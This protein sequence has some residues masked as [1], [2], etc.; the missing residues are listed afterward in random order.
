MHRVFLD[1]LPR[2]MSEIGGGRK[3]ILYLDMDNTLVDFESGLQKLAGA[4]FY[5]ERL[6]FLLIRLRNPKARIIK[7]LMPF[8]I[9]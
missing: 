8:F 2:L 3:K 4:S 9:V 5:E 6:L 7:K 1:E